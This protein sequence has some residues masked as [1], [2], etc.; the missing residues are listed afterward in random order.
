MKNQSLT[1]HAENTE[2]NK[3]SMIN[4]N[5]KVLYHQ[6]KI[7]EL[8]EGMTTSPTCIQVDLE[9]FCNDN[10]GF[11]TTRKDNGYNNE[12]LKLIQIDKPDEKTTI[13]EFLPIGKPSDKSRLDLRMAHDLPKMMKDAN[14]PAIELTGGGEPTL[15][16]AFDT[17]IENLA[18]NDIEI[19]LI[20][21]GSNISEKRAHLLAN[22][23]TW[24]RFS[25][26]ASNQDMHQK[27]H[28]TPNHDFN[29]RIEN[30]R[31]VIRLRNEE[32]VIGVSFIITPINKLDIENACKFYSDIKSEYLRFSWM[33]DRTGNADL[34]NDEISQIKKTLYRC[35]QEYDSEY[36]KVL[37][38]DDRIDLF[39]KP[40][41]DFKKCHM[42]RFVWAIGADANVYPCCIQK[43]NPGFEIG[44]IQEK[45]LQEIIDGEFSKKKINQLDPAGC[46]PCWMR[47]KNKTIDMILNSSQTV[48]DEAKKPPHVNFV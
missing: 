12:M 44:N 9:A 42:Q 29:K 39:S 15:W 16:P 4:N 34:T 36:F 24:I 31:N 41:D 46:H 37:Y 10:C 40:N 11:C 28:R 32:V 2:Y 38:D 27:I 3:I 19:G 47:E 35:K 22:H 45:T 7:K 13:N 20:T 21:N 25:M 43:Y 23:C 1:K 6:N 33:Y 5:S 48:P 30:I 14:I 26:D 8:Q 18:K 17:L